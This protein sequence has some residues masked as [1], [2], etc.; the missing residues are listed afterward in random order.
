MET[1]F[2]GFPC[3]PNWLGTLVSLADI[4]SVFDRELKHKKDER[5]PASLSLLWLPSSLDSCH[6]SVSFTGK[7]YS[8]CASPTRKQ[9]H[10][11]NQ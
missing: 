7:H 4:I 11:N 5:S 9:T 10:V 6:M 1:H 3:F 2:Q 8:G